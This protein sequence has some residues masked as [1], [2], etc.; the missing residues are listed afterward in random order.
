MFAKTA[1]IKLLFPLIAALFIIVIL[2]FVGFKG[3]NDV[4]QDKD[5]VDLIRFSDDVQTAL[6]RNNDYGSVTQEQW[7]FP[8]KYHTLCFISAQTIADIRNSNDELDIS[9]TGIYDLSSSSKK[10]ILRSL[11]Q[12]VSTNLFLI[13]D[14]IVYPLGYSS[15]IVLDEDEED[16]GLGDDG[17]VSVLCKQATN[18]RARFRMQGLGRTTLVLSTNEV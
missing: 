6:Q 17:S 2:S 18:G 13:S 8:G 14:S 12:G 9:L 10:L 5:L 11:E 16:D 4:M 7:V 15:Y 3:V 1:Q